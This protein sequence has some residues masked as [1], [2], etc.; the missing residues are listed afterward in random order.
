[1]MLSKEEQDIIKKH[2]KQ[3]EENRNYLLENN[4]RGRYFISGR[5]Y[6]YQEILT[7]FGEE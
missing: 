2:I 4:F 3:A 1:M 6:A 7:M 5:I